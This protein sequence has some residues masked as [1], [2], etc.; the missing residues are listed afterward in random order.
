MRGLRKHERRLHRCIKQMGQASP[1]AH[2]A[3]VEWVLY[4][5]EVVSYLRFRHWFDASVLKQA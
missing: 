1:E 5:L 4:E 2:D 3:W